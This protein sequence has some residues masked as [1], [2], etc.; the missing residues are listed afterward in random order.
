MTYKLL[1]LDDEPAIL[2]ALSRVINR[3]GA[4]RLGAPCRISAY[5]DASLALTS[6]QS[7]PYDLVITDFRMPAMSGL[8]FLREAIRYQPDIARIII[9]GHADLPTMVAAIND[10][11][12]FRFVGK[13]WDDNELQLAVI[14][15]L[16]VY[17]L[18]RENQRLADLVRVQQGTIS[19]QE[20]E[21]RQLESE[22]PGITRVERDERGAIYL[23]EDNL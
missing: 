8:D 23:D 12:V 5:T 15:A 6:L 16:H 22:C 18:S 13:P 10:T 2:S 4:E 14:Q 3:I 19:R 1:L 17:T 20:A 21:L 11:Q 9:S 7:E